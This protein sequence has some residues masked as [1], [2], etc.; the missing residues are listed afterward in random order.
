MGTRNQSIININKNKTETIIENESKSLYLAQ[1]Y[2]ALGKRSF[3]E[4]KRTL[5]NI[6][7]KDEN[8][9]LPD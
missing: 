3:K 1:D 5:K 6:F 7:K 8:K 9:T 2:V 4:N